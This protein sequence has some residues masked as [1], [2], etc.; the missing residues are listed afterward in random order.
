MPFFFLRPT[1]QGLDGSSTHTP[2]MVAVPCDVPSPPSPPALDVPQLDTR[3]ADD[4]FVVVP[5]ALPWSMCDGML[6]FVRS[7]RS[8]AT[9]LVS[10]N[11]GTCGNVLSG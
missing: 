7:A 4:G 8:A 1:H 10:R 5:G 3:L 6:R 9:A 2:L 11:A